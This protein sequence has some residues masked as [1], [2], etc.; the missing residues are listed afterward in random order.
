MKE[1]YENAVQ[2]TT[3]EVSNKVN[4]VSVDAEKIRNIKDIFEKGIDG[5]VVKNCEQLVAVDPEKLKSLKDMFEKA[6]DGVNEEKHDRTEELNVP[7]GKI[8]SFNQLLRAEFQ[9][10][11]YLM[12][13]NKAIIYWIQ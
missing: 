6:N 2:E 3:N 12:I 9:S 4:D 8:H 1:Q 13:I 7:G 10:I 5:E 11:I